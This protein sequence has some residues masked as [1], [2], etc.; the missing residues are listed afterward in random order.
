IQARELVL[1]ARDR[2]F[3]VQ[4]LVLPVLVIGA[5]IWFNSGG[6]MLTAAWHTP[7]GLAA[8]AF[9]MAAYALMFSAFQTLN[10]EGNALW[11][12]Y[13]VPHSLESIL[14]QKATL[15]GIVCLAYPL[16][17]FAVAPMVG[18]PLPDLLGPAVVAAAGVPIFAV[19]ATALGVFASDPLAQIVQRR[20]R[21]SYMY[22]YMLLAGLYVYAIFAST[23]WQ[24]AGLMVLTALLGLALWQKARDHL[25]YLLDPAESPPARVSL[26]DGLVAAML[27]FV[28]QGLVGVIYA[29]NGYK[30]T[31]SSLLIG[32]A[33][34]GATTFLL[35]RFVFWRLKSAGVPATFGAGGLRA[36]AWGAGAGL[37][38]ALVALA[39]VRLAQH[40]ALFES[41]RQS[42]A[43]ARSD[44]FWLLLLAVVAAP[45]FEEFIFR[46]LIFG[47]LRRTLGPAISVLASAA[48]FALVH[49][50]FSVIPVF[51]LGVA[52]AL[53]YDRSRLLV[54][55]IAAHAVYNAVVVGYQFL[56]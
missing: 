28:A 29:L 21:P 55:P 30:V 49:P 10:T 44:G 2:N 22:L 19:I 42:T 25:P 51:G 52:T 45:I 17:I 9:F 38:M 43:F 11:I 15:W 26:S 46:G 56:L 1:L 35:M 18:T 53:I 5:Q 39:Y 37:A 8:V 50:P 27:F 13:S 31:G 47:G 16:A 20:L 34:A 41:A 33:I 32:F 40:T 4:S 7:S 12:L 14:R 6:E 23:V 54:G 48:I 3:L 24:R 36:I